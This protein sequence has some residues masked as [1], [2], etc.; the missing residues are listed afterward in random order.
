MPLASTPPGRQP[1]RKLRPIRRS[2]S[3]RPAPDCTPCLSSPPARQPHNLPTPLCHRNPPPPPGRGGVNTRDAR[4]TASDAVILSSTQIRPSQAPAHIGM[5]NHAAGPTHR[6]FVVR[7]LDPPPGGSIAD[8]TCKFS[9][10]S[11]SFTSFFPSVVISCLL[12][13][14]HT[15]LCTCANTVMQ[16]DSES[17]LG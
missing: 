15:I 17:S 14:Q 10:R 6:P 13:R 4:H 2:P 7:P 12:R 3:P 9:L 5:K 1:G 8:R 11:T 16:G